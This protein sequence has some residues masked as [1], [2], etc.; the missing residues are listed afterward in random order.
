MP[1]VKVTHKNI[2]GEETKTAP[3]REPVPPA[4]YVA[5][6]MAAPQGVTRGAPPLMKISVEFQIM[7]RAE[8]KNEE[9][10]G[11]RV[12]Q[13]YVLE[14]DPSN[15][16]M[17]KQRAYEL[18]MLLDATGVPYNDAGF[19]TDHLIGK[20]AKVTIRHRTGRPDPANPGAP[21]PVF[22]NVVKVDTTE[23][24]NTDELV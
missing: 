20:T 12:F 8:D 17:S 7:Y 2:T 10:Q 24:V 21:V 23:T 11:R 6:I 14:D 4:E 5:M 13:D 15:S 3:K 1:E 22:S 19:N 9:Q 16:D 18:R